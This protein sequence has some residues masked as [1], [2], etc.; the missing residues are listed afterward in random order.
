[1]RSGRLSA[2]ES[3]KGRFSGVSESLR[4]DSGALP[5]QQMNVEE[6]LVADYAGTGLTVS[7]APCIT[8]APSCAVRV[9]SRQRSYGHAATAN[10]FVPPVV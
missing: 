10:S 7:N 8:A 4:E 5:L 3:R 2:P 9:F 6:R 1:M